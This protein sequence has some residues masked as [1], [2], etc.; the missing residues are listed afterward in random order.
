MAEPPLTLSDLPDG[1]LVLIAFSLPLKAVAALAETSQRFA[2]SVDDD[3]VWKL[4][5]CHLLGLPEERVQRRGNGSFKA[6]L[7]VYQP[8]PTGLITNQLNK[9]LIIEGLSVHFTGKLGSDRAVRANTSLPPLLRAPRLSAVFTSVSTVFS[10]ECSF[11]D[12][13]MSEVFY[14]EVSISSASSQTTDHPER[15]PCISVGLST[16]EFN[17]RHKQA[18]W[19]SS[20]LGFHGDDGVIYHSTGRGLARYGPPFGHGDTVGC[21][22]HLHTKQVFYTL[23]GTYLGPAFLIEQPQIKLFPTVG[24]DSHQRLDLN[25]GRERPFRFDLAAAV[26]SW[27]REVERSGRLPVVT[28]RQGAGHLV[29]RPGLMSGALWGMLQGAADSDDDVDVEDEDEDED[30]LI[31]D[32]EME[33][34]EEFDD[35]EVDTGDEEDEDDSSEGDGHPLQWE[36]IGI[37]PAPANDQSMDDEVEEQG[38]H[39]EVAGLLH[40]PAGAPGGGAAGAAGAM[41]AEYEY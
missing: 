13:H 18:G 21:G 24:I 8:L 3:L 11:F 14:F 25:F 10:G 16:E 40:A 4:H 34:F 9:N 26:E 37:Q 27:S 33:F 6:L 36:G 1:A 32:P 28:S 5:L 41:Q 15:A 38:S 22:V 2:T 35:D 19:T 29:F 20:S 31:G 17:L 12:L 23:N 39:W 30:V 7:K